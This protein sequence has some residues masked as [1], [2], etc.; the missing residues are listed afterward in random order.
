MNQYLVPEEMCVKKMN[1]QTDSQTD[2]DPVSIL[3]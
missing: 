3:C 2:T 1:G